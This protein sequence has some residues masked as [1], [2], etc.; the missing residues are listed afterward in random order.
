MSNVKIVSENMRE[1]K[2]F[3][4]YS[5]DNA[6]G[7]HSIIKGYLRYSPLKTHFVSLLSYKVCW[8]K[9]NRNRFSR[10]KCLK[11]TTIIS[12]YV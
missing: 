2:D 4:F 10:I 11:E 5:I 7:L 6:D 3:W 1:V 8:T 12:G 9:G